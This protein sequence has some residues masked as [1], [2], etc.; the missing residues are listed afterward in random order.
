MDSLKDSI[1]KFLR[2]D[3][4]I[5]NLTGYVEAQVK[6]AK[7]EVR[8]EVAKILS[9]GLVIGSMLLFAFLFLLFFSVGMAHYLN[10]VF[11]QPFIGYWLVALFY[12][13]PC[14]VFLFFYKPISTAI[15]KYFAKHIKNKD[16]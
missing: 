15:E 5:S 3:N 2:L 13:I 7:L 11:E 9:R 12:A 16:K 14:I 1:V 10:G 4:L 6:L 8:D